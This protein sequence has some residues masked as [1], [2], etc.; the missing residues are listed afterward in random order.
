MPPTGTPGLA[1][2]LNRP[3]DHCLAPGTDG[4]LLVDDLDHLLPAAPPSLDSQHR[5]GRR[6]HQLDS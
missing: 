4:H 5:I 6:A 3:R 1:P 2:T